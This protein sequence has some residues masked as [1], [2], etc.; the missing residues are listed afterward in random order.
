MLA[1]GGET[2]QVSP[3]RQ[4]WNPLDFAE[5][6]QNMSLTR[7]DFHRP[8]LNLRLTVPSTAGL[9][10]SAPASACI[11][12]APFSRKRRAALG[13]SGPVNHG[14]AG[15]VDAATVQAPGRENLEESEQ[16]CLGA[17]AQ[18]LTSLVPPT[19]PASRLPGR[20]TGPSPGAILQAAG[21]AA[22]RPAKLLHIP[23]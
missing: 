3:G 14:A 7:G 6:I 21:Q 4:R 5:R 16:S 10:E 22:R 8:A 19:R 12:P 18:K 2:R 1:E 13:K 23:A 11:G 20:R 17:C 9:G 15:V